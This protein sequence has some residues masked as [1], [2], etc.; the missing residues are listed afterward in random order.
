MHMDRK[1]RAMGPGL[2]CRSVAPVKR[3]SAG[4]ETASRRDSNPARGPPGLESRLQ[5]DPLPDPAGLRL[6]WS[7]ETGGQETASRRDSNP[8]RG[9]RGL[10]SRLQADPLPDPAGRPLAWSTETG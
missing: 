3:P 10:E 2:A 8:A 5:A 6:A 1:P 4:Q 7:T 9:P